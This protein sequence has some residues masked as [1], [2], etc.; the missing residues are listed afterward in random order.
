MIT[1]EVVQGPGAVAFRDKDPR[2]L[3]RGQE[4][5]LKGLKQV[6]ESQS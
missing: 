1:E 3:H 5:W 4:I 2:A 6:S